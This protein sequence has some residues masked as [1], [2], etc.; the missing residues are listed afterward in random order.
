MSDLRI[1][2]ARAAELTGRL[3]EL[4]DELNEEQAE[5]PD[6]VPVNLLIGC[7]VPAEGR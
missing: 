4:M 1:S 6:G 5:D 2:P 7:Y 3:K